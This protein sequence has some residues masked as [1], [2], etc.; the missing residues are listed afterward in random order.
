[1]PWCAT[2]SPPRGTT[3]SPGWWTRPSPC[4][5]WCCSSRTRAAPSAP[6]AGGALLHQLRRRPRPTPRAEALLRSA[7]LLY[8]VL[9][10]YAC[11]RAEQ[12]V[13]SAGDV[14]LGW[15]RQVAR[16]LRSSGMR[17]AADLS[18]R[19]ERAHLAAE[20]LDDLAAMMRDHPCVVWV[21][22]FYKGRYLR[23]TPRP[24]RDLCLDCTVMAVK[25]LARGSLPGTPPWRR[26]RDWRWLNNC[27]CCPWCLLL[28]NQGEVCDGRCRYSD[29][30]CCCCCCCWLL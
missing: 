22:N 26:F 24:G 28:C 13:V 1:V 27:W 8:R 30:Q 3:S 9:R 16:W 11:P 21:D 19:A 18:N 23:W 4:C 7:W 15:T 14:P 6:A 12:P 25:R 29:W 17:P 10:Q 5:P 2:P 20:R